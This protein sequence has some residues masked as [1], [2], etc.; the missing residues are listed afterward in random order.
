MRLRAIAH[1]AQRLQ[2]RGQGTTLDIG[3]VK[4]D[5]GTMWGQMVAASGASGSPEVTG[6]YEEE[7]QRMAGGNPQMLRMLQSKLVLGG[8][9]SPYGVEQV[10]G[11]KGMPAG[12]FAALGAPAPG[13]AAQAEQ[14]MAERLRDLQAR[15]EFGPEKM[16]A[17]WEQTL[18][19]MG[20][21]MVN[22]QTEMQKAL[23]GAID[24]A[25]D[26]IPTWSAMKDALLGMGDGARTLLG[27]LTLLSSTN[28]T[29]SLLGGLLAAPGIGRAL[30]VTPPEWS[31]TS[32]WGRHPFGLTIPGQELFQGPG[33]GSGFL[34]PTRLG[35]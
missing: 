27:I 11:S 4:A 15:P 10:Y 12:G 18:L 8:R 23:A 32:P 19:P 3:G 29:M 14:T 26:G 21:G 24:A 34:G 7:A 22:M 1:L 16:Q 20:K 13:A 25:K 17:M 28:T 6:A 9:F 5:I 31:P 33:P 2:A 30:D 35:P